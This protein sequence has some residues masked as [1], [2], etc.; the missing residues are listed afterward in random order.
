MNTP[1]QP[2]PV[3]SAD[4][5]G[6]PIQI[7]DHNGQRWITAEQAGLALGYNE[8]NARDGAL[9]LFNRNKDEFSAQDSTTVKLTAVDN[10]NREVRIFSATGCQLLGFFSSTARAKEFRAW[11]KCVLA[12]DNNNTLLLQAQL[13][14]SQQLIHQLKDKL[15]SQHLRYRQVYRYLER[16]FSTIEIARCL[17]V[18]SRA[19]RMILSEM[20]E[21][22][23]LPEHQVF[24][25]A[26]T[27]RIARTVSKDLEV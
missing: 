5:F 19:I 7:I 23:L 11:A 8:A 24:T 17:Q 18:S 15:M 13:I 25:F 22:G 12:Q 9:K 14:E 1:T 21:L 27:G 16:N 3:Q 10:K 26:H 4:F 2:Y 6:T 20:R